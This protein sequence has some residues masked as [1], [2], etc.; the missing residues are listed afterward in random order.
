MLYGTLNA[1]LNF[2]GTDEL[3]VFFGE[4]EDEEGGDWI[5]LQAKTN[6]EDYLRI[7]ANQYDMGFQRVS[8]DGYVTTIGTI[9]YHIE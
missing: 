7:Y 1:S 9:K 5:A 6:T 4:S 3:D 8:K 2:F